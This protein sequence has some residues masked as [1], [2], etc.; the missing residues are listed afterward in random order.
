[1]SVFK[2]NMARKLHDTP[3]SIVFNLRP[4]KS[5]KETCSTKSRKKNIMWSEIISEVE[6]IILG[7]LT[8]ILQKK[9]KIQIKLTGNYNGTNVHIS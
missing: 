9:Q 2:K 8:H 1:M 6:E 3:T 4:Y 7:N 5:K